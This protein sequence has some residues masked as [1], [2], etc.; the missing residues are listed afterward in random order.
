MAEGSRQAREGLRGEAVRPTRV[1]L[2]QGAV[3]FYVPDP[4]QAQRWLWSV[5]WPGHRCHR[6]EDEDED[7][8]KRW[9]CR[10][11]EEYGG[12]VPQTYRHGSCSGS[13]NVARHAIADAHAS[14]PPPRYIGMQ[15]VKA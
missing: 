2:P 13:E 5:R 12:T 10:R 4:G 9:H 7:E 8:G 1:D 11:G 6:L 15:Y 14:G 3:G